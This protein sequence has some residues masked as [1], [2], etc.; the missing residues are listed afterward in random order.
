MSDTVVKHDQ[1][2]KPYAYDLGNQAA[3]VADAG[4]RAGLFAAIAA[5]GPADI[6]EDGRAAAP[7]Y[8]ARC[9]RVWCRATHAFGP[10]DWDAVSGDRLASHMDTP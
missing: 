3:W 7:G 2:Q 1:W 8:D 9:T 10:L 4:P 5:A 6:G